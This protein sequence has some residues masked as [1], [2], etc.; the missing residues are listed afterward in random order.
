M[1][2]FIAAGLI[3]LNFAAVAAVTVAPWA[4]GG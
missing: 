1:S 3:A 4:W 2:R